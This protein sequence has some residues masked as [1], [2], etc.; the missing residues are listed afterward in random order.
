MLALWIM[1]SLCVTAYAQNGQNMTVNFT[2]DELADS[3]AFLIERVLTLAKKGNIK[4]TVNVPSGT[5]K[6]TRPMHIYSNTTLHLEKDTVFVR[7]FSSANMLKTG[8]ASDVN[9]G[10]G[11]YHDITVYGGIWDNQFVSTTC[12]MRFL[13]CENVTLKNLTVKNIYDSHH[14]E[15]G[16]ARN[17]LIEN[18][19][20]TGYKRSKNTS[21]EA[22]QIDPVHSEKHFK[23]CT[24]LDDTP[25]RDITVKNC[26]FQNV[27]S[28]VGTR[29]GVVG[30]YFE[31]INIVGN[32]FE[33]ISDKAICTFN[34]LHSKIKNNV[35]QNASV[36]I[37]FEAYPTKNLT[38]KLYMPHSSKA[39]KTIVT[40]LDCSITGNRIMVR[41]HT[42]YA[43]S[44]GI[45]VYGG[46]L[47]KSTA[48][49]TGLKQGRYLAENMTVRD[50]RILVCSASSCGMELKYVN[51]SKV[52]GNSISSTVTANKGM[53]GISLYRA[54][55]NT[56]KSNTVNG[57]FTQGIVL[58]D[59]SSLIELQ[60]NKLG[61]TQYYGI[62]VYGTSKA[63]IPYGN[64]ISGCG[65]GS[66]YIKDKEIKVPA[67][68][69]GVTISRKKKTATVKWK[70][71]KKASGY[72]VYRSKTKNGKYKLVA[73][74]KKKK[75]T[76]YTDKTSKK[77]YYKI[78]PYKTYNQT[79]VVGK[80]S[81]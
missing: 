14:I 39:S 25:C 45:G 42:G 31:R 21:G 44:C 18:V 5:Y 15:I 64:S 43:Q 59:Y 78:T 11:G 74:L 28:G 62:T 79:E 55:N 50:N 46:I 63:H 41:K 72:Y 16:A 35:I 81:A 20:L 58:Y 22:I 60:N 52:S 65:K 69:G 33:N 54:N 53:T 34:Y 37:F 49:K 77:Y 38:A 61:G 36:G 8:T 29:A 4:L 73:T 17:M 12:G 75:T 56:V 27:F 32:T 70:K 67:L 19:T 57:A 2:Q 26:T 1:L 30:S 40:N 24:Y 47:S 76:T 51:H 66:I 9:S 80:M 6:L 23:S 71:V 68:K 3:P 7:G 10:Y 13:H 48:N